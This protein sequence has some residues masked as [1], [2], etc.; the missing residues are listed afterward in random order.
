MREAERPRPLLLATLLFVMPAVLAGAA[1]AVYWADLIAGQHFTGPWFARAA[2]SILILAIPGA[3]MASRGRKPGVL[4]L[5]LGFLPA[6]I[7]IGAPM[8][9]RQGLASPFWMGEMLVSEAR[10]AMLEGWASVLTGSLLSA[11]LVGSYCI[12]E[13]LWPSPGSRGAD[14]WGPG[15]ERIPLLISGPAAAL[16]SAIAWRL[17]RCSRRRATLAPAPQRCARWKAA[18]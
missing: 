13:G 17:I 9:R 15:R 11:A 4:L 6:V 2:L 5:A 3:L 10:A 16:L 8:I 14:V 12:L 7:G 18:P 1:A